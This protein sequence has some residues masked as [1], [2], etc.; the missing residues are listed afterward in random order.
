MS[1]IFD[2]LG[3]EPDE[4]RLVAPGLA[5]A[6]LALGAQT[7]ASIA[8]DALFVSTFSLGDLSRFSAIASTIR[9]VVAFGYAALAARIATARLDRVLLAL[10]AVLFVAS[11]A[12]TRG[13][14]REII[15]AVCLLQLLLPPLLPLFAF[16]AILGCFRPRQAKRILPLVAAAA[17]LG[18]MAASAGARASAS[19]IGAAPLF[20]VAAAMCLPALPIPSLL[21]ARATEAGVGEAPIVRGSA[22]GFVATIQ[23]TLRDFRDVPVARLVVLVAIASS[24]GSTFADFAFKAALKAE[25]SRDAL[26][27]FLGTFN[28]LSNGLV[29]LVQ[30]FVASRFVGRFGVRAS[31]QAAPASLVAFG[32]LFGLVPGVPV[33]VTVKLSD[34]V[35]RYGLGGSTADLVL[36]PAPPPVRTRAKVFV[37]GVASPLGALISSLALTAFGEHGPSHAVLA[38]ML[39]VSGLLGLVI[40]HDARRAYTMALS[41]ALG[42]GRISLDVSPASAAA[43]KTELL[44]ILRV[45]CERG[46]RKEAARV[47]AVM[48][49]R[50]FSLADLEGVVTA[51]RTDP[52]IRRSAVRA[53]LL[54]AQPGEGDRLLALAPPDD[55]PAIERDVL[56]GARER[57]AKIPRERL[58]R[59]ITLG[60]SHE[61]GAPLW[62]EAHVSLAAIDLVAGL[63]PLRKAALEA[64]SPRRAAAMRG[65]GLVGDTRAEREV[66]RGMASSDAHVFAEA[67]AAA[68]RLDAQG[69]IETLVARLSTG[70]H[71]RPCARALALA[72]PRAVNALVAALPTTRGEKAILPTAVASG[73]SVT[74]TIR[75]ARV[76]AR[77]GPEGATRALERYGDVG[78]RA[79]NAIA[80]AFAA[81]SQ[82]SVGAMDPKVVLDAME[83]TVAYAEGLVEGLAGALPGLFRAE[84]AHRIGE[85]GER[86]LDL[87]S[88]VGDRP[89]IARARAALHRDARDR[90]NALELLEN[91]L[92]RPLAARTVALLDAAE[93]ATR[94]SVPVAVAPRATF[95][96]WLEKCRR[97]DQKALGSDEAMLPILERVL[98]LRDASLFAG[99]SGEELYPVAE[100]SEPVHVDAGQA[101]VREGDPGDALFVVANG[102]L[103]VERGG[104]RLR[105]IGP[106]AAFG[107]LA[108]LDG[109]PRAASVIAIDSA[110]LL[111]IPRAEFEALL[112]ESPELARGV[113][114]T[115]IG[116]LRGGS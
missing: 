93:A 21:A 26:A 105:E 79:R 42:E 4:R 45:A 47:L 68:V 54:L 109:A 92:P 23:G 1:K 102:K 18:T 2:L 17:T 16:N 71:V 25:Y 12:L 95:D 40:A 86:V 19:M 59:A 89:L 58:D 81:V 103:S 13:G 51:A 11:G 101:V 37:K 50:V 80:R 60:A 77:L 15:Y 112:D 10:T 35:T 44:H 64:D 48:S 73:T 38:I 14:G 57:G 75:A 115:L 85:T 98:I 104:N 33:A 78:Y 111:R 99:L 63:K 3:V 36:T 62:G 107:E 91:V 34:L 87:A 28:V 24:A 94:P 100:I 61:Q 69:A 31:L 41:A 5:F 72:G 74:G 82:N 20:F 67:A 53:A 114:R 116:H 8:A 90:E 46:D 9:V 110:R 84:V 32:P 43:V 113:I 49:D 7:V 22:P 76:L 88:V 70:P 55:D 97:F 66:L 83:L 65:I 6:F 27:A 106:G 56:E 30:L 96:G 52:E 108:L 39:A 29:L